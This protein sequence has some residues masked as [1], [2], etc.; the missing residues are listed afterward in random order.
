MKVYIPVYTFCSDCGQFS[1]YNDLG[2]VFNLKEK[3]EVYLSN[4]PNDGKRWGDG[5]QILELELDES[6]R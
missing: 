1:G 6:S 2:L 4:H 3:A 5:Q